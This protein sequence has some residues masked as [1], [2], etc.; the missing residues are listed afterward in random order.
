VSVHFQTAQTAIGVSSFFR[1]SN[2]EA[3]IGVSS[4]FR[5]KTELDTDSIENF[6]TGRN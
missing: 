1:G 6:M 5:A 4:F 3:T 2:T